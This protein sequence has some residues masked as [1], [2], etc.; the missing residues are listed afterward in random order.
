VYDV[1][2]QPVSAPLGQM[3][4]AASPNIRWRERARLV[5]QLER[6]AEAKVMGS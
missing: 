6:V 2:G 3:R 1:Q 4:N 5:K